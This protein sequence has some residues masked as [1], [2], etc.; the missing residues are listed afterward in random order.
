MYA[1]YVR[2]RKFDALRHSRK[3]LAWLSTQAAKVGVTAKQL[4]EG[5]MVGL[6]LSAEQIEGLPAGTAPAVTS[7][8]ITGTAKVGVVLTATAVVT[9]SPTPTKTYSWLINAIQVGTASTYTPV[10]GDVGKTVTCKVTAAN[11][12]GSA[13]ATSAAT[14][15]VVA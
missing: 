14:A 13:N 1:R 11:G 8:T 2:L 5:Y 7:V 10:V 4:F 12:K 3:F 6:S 15:A 9:G